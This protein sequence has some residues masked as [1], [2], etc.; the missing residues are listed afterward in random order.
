MIFSV[1]E[2]SMP[3]WCLWKQILDESQKLH[4]FYEYFSSEGSKWN[5][6]R[7][8]KTVTQHL[9]TRNYGLCALSDVKK[10][11]SNQC[12]L[13]FTNTWQNTSP[14]WICATLYEHVRDKYVMLREVHIVVI[15][16]IHLRI[17]SGPPTQ[18]ILYVFYVVHD[19]GWSGPRQDVDVIWAW[20]CVVIL[21]KHI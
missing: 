13:H 7:K 14:H 11:F 15:Y 21:S 1:I 2:S 8:I 5:F 12:D 16:R 10:I 20:N 3:Y 6:L 9:E 17:G 19:W 18:L 4:N